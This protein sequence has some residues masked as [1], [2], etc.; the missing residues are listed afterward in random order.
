MYNPLNTTVHTST[1]YLTVHR[2]RH[3]ATSN[4]FRRL[5]V[6]GK[7]PAMGPGQ[8]VMMIL[9]SRRWNLAGAWVFSRRRFQ[10]LKL[11]HFGLLWLWVLWH[12]YGCWHGFGSSGGG[13]VAV[14]S[15]EY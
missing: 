2:L 15:G 10:H 1:T 13:H 9:G 3:A 14:A 7:A 11:Q 6:H 12:V 8:P 5:C 4:S